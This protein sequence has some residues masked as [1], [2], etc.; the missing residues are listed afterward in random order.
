MID[1]LCKFVV[2]AFLPNV[3]IADQVDYLAAQGME[4]REFLAVNEWLMTYPTAE[5]GAAMVQQSMQEKKED[6]KDSPLDYV[7]CLQLDRHTHN[8][9]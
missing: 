8:Y 7:E 2:I 4:Y 9:R 3:T 6:G 1:F 5:D